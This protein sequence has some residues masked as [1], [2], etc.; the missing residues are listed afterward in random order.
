MSPS[1][2]VM[3]DA[4]QLRY[5]RHLLLNEWSEPVQQRLAA[6]HAVVVGAGGL[7]A[8]ALMYLAAAGVGRLTVIDPDEV[9]LSNLQ[10]QVLH[11]TNTI[12]HSKVASAQAGL[13][14]LNPHVQVR[15]VHRAADAAWLAA[16]LPGCDIVLDCTDRF[17]IRHAINLA[18]WRAGVPV[19]SAS[20]VGWDAQLTLFDPSQASSPCYA[21]LF[22]PDAP[23]AETRCALM[24]VFAPLVGTIGVMQAGEAIKRLACLHQGAGHQSLAGRL[25]LLDGREWRWTELRTRPAPRCPVCGPR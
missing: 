4:Q 15:A 23:P 19:V 14:A 25:L 3:D 24:G 21:C 8:P 16:E 20:A 7:G 17:D 11:R 9:E 18:A 6:A 12:G 10:R 1:G 5:S 22:P 2:P 13:A